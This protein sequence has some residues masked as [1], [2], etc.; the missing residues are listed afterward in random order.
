MTWWKRLFGSS[1]GQT[2]PETRI[3]YRT[4]RTGTTRQDAAAEF[5]VKAAR[6]GGGGAIFGF[7]FREAKPAGKAAEATP[8]DVVGLLAEDPEVQVY[9]DGTCNLFFHFA[10]DPADAVVLRL[11]KAVK[12]QVVQPRFRTSSWP[13][14]RC[15]GQSASNSRTGGDCPSGGCRSRGFI[16]WPSR[17]SVIAVE[18]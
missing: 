8:K 18:V 5:G 12:P 4:N 7:G 14:S 15:P 11:A 10:T 13:Y 9:T 3:R 17:S 2:G 1:E 16:L 6:G